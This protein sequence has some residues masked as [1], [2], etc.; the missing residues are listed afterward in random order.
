L[1]HDDVV[2]A[3]FRSLRPKV[4]H[5]SYPNFVGSLGAKSGCVFVIGERPSFSESYGAYMPELDARLRTLRA[6]PELKEFLKQ[7]SPEFHVT[8]C[9]K[10]RG[11]SSSPKDE[12]TDEMKSLSRRCLLAEFD[13][14]KP[15]VVLLSCMAAKICLAA[16]AL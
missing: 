13:L 16:E 7:Q 12:P 8:D 4:H 2:D 6:V 9:I 11:G 10:F 1:P 3:K 14:L 5:A 15:K